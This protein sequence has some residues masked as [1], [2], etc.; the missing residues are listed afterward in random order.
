MPTKIKWN[1]GGKWGLLPVDITWGDYKLIEEI[2]EEIDVDGIG[3]KGRRERLERLLDQDKK[4]KKRL[5]HLICRVKGEK[6][7]D[8]KKE[9]GDVQV[10]LE[11]VELVI[12][13]VI[14]K[15]M[16]VEDIDVV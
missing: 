10:K 11:D 1:E 13:R 14:G 15:K 12:E 8:E 4:K 5:I 9:V 7:Y 16:I 3:T 2:A 6:V